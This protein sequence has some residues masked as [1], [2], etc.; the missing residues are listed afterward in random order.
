MIEI[1]HNIPLPLK[2]SKKWSKYPF[3]KMEIG[4]SFLFSSDKTKHL[5]ARSSA[6]LKAKKLSRKFA[7]RITDEGVRIWRTE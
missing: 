3:E 7:V 4:D 6:C 5:T 2:G 1:N